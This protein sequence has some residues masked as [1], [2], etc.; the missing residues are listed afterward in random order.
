MRHVHAQILDE[1][2]K[3]KEAGQR[4]LQFR[5]LRPRC[6]WLGACQGGGGDGRWRRHST[7]QAEIPEAVEL[8]SLMAATRTKNQV[9]ASSFQRFARILN[10]GL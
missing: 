8:N 7:V 1:R 5:A 9:V 10:R 3:R 6:F 4:G 2:R